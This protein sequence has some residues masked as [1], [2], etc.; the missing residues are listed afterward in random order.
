MRQ[1]RR[2][3]LGPH[4]PSFAAAPGAV[5]RAVRRT[6]EQ[7][8]ATLV[9]LPPYSPDLNPI[10]Q[11]LAKL[12]PLLRRAGE[13]TREALRQ[14]IASLLDRFTPDECANYLHASGY[15]SK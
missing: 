5:D 1:S 6:I 9:F 13:R 12:K 3:P 10:K 14:R 15:G 7:R 11:L 4:S 2:D 8:G